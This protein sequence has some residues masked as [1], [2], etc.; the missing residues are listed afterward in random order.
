MLQAYCVKCK[1]QREMQNP[2]PMFNARGAAYT[3]GT[4]AV[5]GTKMTRWG[6]TELHAAVGDGAREREGE[7]AREREG[8]RA[9]ERESERAREREIAGAET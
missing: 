9:R 7:R 5:C 3:Q 2:Q 8:E 6:A 1:T 4:C